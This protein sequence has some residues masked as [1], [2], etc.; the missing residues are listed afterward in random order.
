VGVVFQIALIDI[1]FSLD[2]VFTAIGF[3]QRI[4]VMVAAIVLAM[5][6]MMLVAARIGLSSK[7]IRRSRSWHWRSCCWSASLSLLMA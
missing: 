1:V 5:I 6:F 7:T 3:A 4:E 2:S